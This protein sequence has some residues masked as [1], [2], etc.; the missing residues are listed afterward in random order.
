MRADKPELNKKGNEV[1]NHLKEMW[2]KKKNF[3]Q[4]DHCSKIKAS[5]LNSNRLH[6]NRIGANILSSSF[7][8]HISKVFNLQLSGNTSCFNFCESDFKKNESSNLKQAKDSF[9]R[10]LNALR[11]DNS[12]KLNFAHLNINS[13]RNQFAYLSEQIRVM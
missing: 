3:F 2:K 12:G 10:V 4:I 13:I 9:R 6:L 1:N 5:H 7:A 11:K 8:Q